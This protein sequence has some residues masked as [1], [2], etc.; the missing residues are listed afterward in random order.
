MLNK[1]ILGAAFSFFSGFALCADESFSKDS[2]DRASGY[3]GNLLKLAAAGIGVPESALKYEGSFYRF[4]GCTGLFSSPKGP[5]ECT[6]AA[7]STDGG[8]T[9]FIGIPTAGYISGMQNLCQKAK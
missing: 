9:Y 4:P 1:F 6:L 3:S 7:W 8:K 2:C 5:Y